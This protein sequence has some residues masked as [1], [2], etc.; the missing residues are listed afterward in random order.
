MIAR[1]KW[2]GLAALAAL[3]LFAAALMRR[4][5]RWAFFLVH[6]VVALGESWSERRTRRRLARVLTAHA[7][8]SSTPED[9]A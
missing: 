1:S 9:R 6:V 5:F 4:R 7:A 8:N 3:G 2:P